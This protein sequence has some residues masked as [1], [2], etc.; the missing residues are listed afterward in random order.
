MDG[1][2]LNRRPIADGIIELNW[3]G[4]PD[5]DQLETLIRTATEDALVRGARRV[6]LR[7]PTEDR[8][9][10]RAA[11][12]SGFRSKVS[13]GAFSRAPTAAGPTRRCSPVCPGTRSVARWDSPR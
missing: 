8:F 6:E 2:E 4:D 5:P 7:A 13:D 3:T 1:I 12:R 9:T 10:R 11:L